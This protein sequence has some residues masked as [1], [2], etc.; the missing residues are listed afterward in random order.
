[1]NQ[2]LT[3]TTRP[4]FT[5]RMARVFI[6]CLLVAVLLPAF[7]TAA[8]RYPVRGARGMVVSAHPAASEAGV[9]MLRLGGNA[10]D[11]AVA[12]ALV[13][14]VVEPYS[15]GIGGGGFML[16]RDGST[17][18]IHVIDYREVAPAAATRDMYLDAKGDVIPGASDVGHL[19]AAVPGTVAGLHLAQQKYGKLPWKKVVAP[20]IKWAD[21]GFPAD[22]KYIGMARA[23]KAR[24]ASHPETARTFLARGGE[25][26]AY[27]A[28]IRQRDLAKTLRLI[29]KRGPSAFYTGKIA[30]A[31]AAEMAAN[32]GLI[33]EADLANYKPREVE[34]LRGTWRGYEI[35]TMPPP[36]SGGVHLIQM[37]NVLEHSD[38]SASGWNSSATIHLLAETMRRAYADRAEFLGDPAF[39]DVPVEGLTSKEYAKDLFTGISRSR[40]TP[41]ASIGHGDP[42]KYESDDTT[43]LCTIDADGYA[44]SLTQTINYSFGSGV[45]IPGTG[46]LMNNEMD[47]FSAKAGVPNLY[48]LVGSDANAIAGGKI[49]L[50]SMTPTMVLRD[51]KPVLV[52]GSPGGARIITTVLNVVLNHLVFGMDVQE[53]VDAPRIHH[54]WLPDELRVEPRAVSRDVVRILESMGHKVSEQPEFGSAMAIGVDAETGD[55]LGA[56]DS[57]GVGAAVGF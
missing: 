51:G 35:V 28:T 37:L 32:G 9:E 53:A 5:D 34:P 24:L 8:S 38:L 41:S 7:A 15:A 19:A 26:P 55:F 30:K 23:E 2:P 20:A 36:S 50:S 57:R 10:V 6:A 1:M 17:G 4:P 13:A 22:D 3:R 27:G 52:V 44:V 16:I 54:Q 48:G 11:A 18:Q 46:I 43:H 40:A 47:D 33:T 31:I 56:A 42:R 25:V 14:G 45:T 39:V 12:T 21:E 49:P 29:A